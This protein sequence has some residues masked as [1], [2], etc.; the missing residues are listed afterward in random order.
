SALAQALPQPL[1]E[2]AR[3]AVVGNPEI[4][5]KWREFT[6]AG[7]EH[8]FARSGQRPRLDLIASAGRQWTNNRPDLSTNL[9][10]YRN[11]QGVTLTQMLFD[12]FYTRN[13][14]SRLGY[15]KL[16][17][18]YELLESSENITLEA[19]R[20]YA[21]V[22]KQLELVE[23]AKANYIEHKLITQLIEERTSAGVS[24]G[25]D[26]EQATGRLALAESNLIT[27][28]SNLH[29]VSARYLRVVGE[30]P[31]DNVPPLPERLKLR[32]LPASSTQAMNEGLPSSPTINAA[33]ENVRSAKAQVESN[34]SGYY[35]RLD[36]RA[37]QNWSNNYA[38]TAGSW[39]DAYAELAL[40]Y[41]LY[42][43]GADMA[44]EKQAIEL[45]YQARDLQEKACR[46][47]RQNLIIAYNDLTRLLDQLNFLDQHRLS[48]EKA[49]Q[50]YRQQ[51][52]IGQRTLLDML[53]TQNEYFEASRAYTNA[54]YNQIMAQARTL[55][56]MGRL[57]ATLGVTRPDQPTAN[58]AGQDRGELPPDE[59]C[60]FEA[61]RLMAIDKAKM[62]AD[63][64]PYRPRSEPVAVAAPA[65][66]P[67]PVPVIPA[68][69]TFASDALFDFDKSELKAEGKKALDELIGKIKSVDLQLAIAVGHTDSVGSEAYN[70]ALSTRRA[71]S[72][73]SYMVS[74]GL[75][76][77]KITTVGKGESQPVAS[78]DTA[79]GRAKNRRVDIEVQ[80]LGVKK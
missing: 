5:A 7:H 3:K 64:L 15:A 41:N 23:A 68:K 70:L 28:I 47:V 56:G 72:V 44:R 69:S 30:R 24:R 11:G 40:N 35:P 14:I 13:E 75:P 6:A 59:L 34:K 60:P 27:E 39:T 77:N 4:Q 76:A 2:V 18:Y 48:T 65:P 21:D 79:Q 25:V 67:V 80:V 73:K 33:Y 61:P 19:M 17:R 12:G 78:N 10:Y 20:A 43:G 51:F 46:D 57:T 45:R 49:R 52:E 26:L 32:G 54:R 74:Q 36:F 53:N 22:A 66:A 55:A 50:A 38:G 71:E 63:V 1:I 31:G 29:D 9:D 62:V 16:V 58:D 37:G 42:R 8:E